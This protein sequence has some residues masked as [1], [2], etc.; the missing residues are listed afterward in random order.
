MSR[1]PRPAGPPFAAPLVAGSPDQKPAKGRTDA[2]ISTI[3]TKSR[4]SAG[5]GQSR[6]F[7]LRGQPPGETGPDKGVAPSTGRLCNRKETFRHDEV[8]DW[9]DGQPF[10]GISFLPALLPRGWH[11]RMPRGLPALPTVA[12]LSSR[13]PRPCPFSSD[14]YLALRTAV[15][16]AS[17]DG[18]ALLLGDGMTASQPAAELGCQLG[19]P[20]IVV[21]AGD[22]RP[23]GRRKAKA[24]MAHPL[25]WPVQLIRVDDA[26]P[27]IG[28]DELLA[29]L[30]RQVRVLH[31]VEGS[32]TER[33]VRKRLQA[34]PPSG[35][36]WVRADR[37]S[38]GPDSASGA[39]FDAGAVP[40]LL[41]WQPFSRVRTRSLAGNRQETGSGPGSLRIPARREC[42]M[43]PDPGGFRIE[44]TGAPDAPRPQLPD[45]WRIPDR[46]LLHWTR[47]SGRMTRHGRKEWELRLWLGDLAEN[48]S[49]RLKPLVSIIGGGVLRASS[50]LNRESA[51]VVS[52]TAVP[53]AEFRSRRVFRPHLQRYDFELAGIGIRKERLLELGARPVVYGDD[54]AW[55]QMAAHDRLW[56]HPRG[57]VAPGPAGSRGLGRWE[58]EREWRLPGDLNLFRFGPADLVVFVPD[59]EA[60]SLVE[61]FSRWPVV[62]APGTDTS[63]E[64]DSA[65]AFSQPDSLPD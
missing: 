24:G 41:G 57:K 28:L 27:D 48:I 60:L 26:A 54:E 39:L 8:P 21:S 17:Q 29:G 38:T 11:A 23:A 9:I 63:A 33:A 64:R 53:L 52:L 49:E 25:R 7:G 4:P 10:E 65:S 32:R 1:R 5:D 16:R 61:T 15:V 47:A 37:S 22:C 50:R 46:W 42:E 19:I 13:L 40:W 35:S 43:G 14:W 2:A 45:D 55:R 6:Q 30:A 34:G 31:V 12:L 59:Q 44:L 51:P 18:Q 62:I 58:A 20:M 56:F 36:T 3:R